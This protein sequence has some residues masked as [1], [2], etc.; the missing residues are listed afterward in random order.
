MPGGPAPLPLIPY[1]SWLGQLLGGPPPPPPPLGTGGSG[2]AGSSSNPLTAAQA[3][4]LFG[5]MAGQKHIPFG[6]AID[7][8]YA[9]AHEMSRLLQVKGVETEKAWNYGDLKVP[10]TPVGDVEW[11]YHVAPTVW[12]A[13]PGGTAQRMVIDPSMFPKPVTDLQWA[14]AMNDPNARLEHSPSQI[15]YRP[16]GSAPGVGERDDKYESTRDTLDQYTKELERI[17]GTSTPP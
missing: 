6:Y 5:E 11:G 3:D 7:G 2:A 17:K 8:C 1:P 10:G 14:A 15:Y 9:R 4:G 16:E 13:G 12:V